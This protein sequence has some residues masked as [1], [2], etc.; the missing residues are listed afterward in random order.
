VLDSLPQTINNIIIAKK[1]YLGTFKVIM[2]N[3]VNTR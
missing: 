1:V 2:N 3:L